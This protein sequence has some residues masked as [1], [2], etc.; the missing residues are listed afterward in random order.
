MLV[1]F[2]RWNNF[3]TLK[4]LLSSSKLALYWNLVLQGDF[5]VLEGKWVQGSKRHNFWIF[6]FTGLVK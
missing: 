6:E 2:K 3:L 4:I 1:G 5:E